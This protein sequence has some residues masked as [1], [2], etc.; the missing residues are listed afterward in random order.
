MVNV[1]EELVK[2]E[3]YREVSDRNPELDEEDSGAYFRL[4][5]NKFDKES[6]LR[7]ECREKMIVNSH[8]L[9]SLFYD[10]IQKMSSGYEVLNSMEQRLRDEIVLEKIVHFFCG[11]SE[12]D[13]YRTKMTLSVYRLYRDKVKNKRKSFGVV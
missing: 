4:C 10:W 6:H 12:R 7:M 11:K 1:I 13:N 9:K 8:S 3:I 2:A 5:M